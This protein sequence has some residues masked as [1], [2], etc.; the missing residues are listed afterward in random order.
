MEK[1]KI[2]KFA[3]IGASGFVA[4]RHMRAISEN[5]HKL[6][7]ALD[8]HDAVGVLDR[9]FL[10]TDYFR[11]IERF[12]RHLEKLK[13][14]G[15]GVDYLSI[16]SPNYLHDAH[17]RFGLKLG[18]DVICEK[19]LVLNS[20][21]LDGLLEIEKETGQRIYTILQLRLHPEIIK[22]KSKID[23]E[24]NNKFYHIDLDYLTTRGPW[25]NYSWKGDQSKSGGIATNIGIHFFDM[26]IWI[27]GDVI[28]NDMLKLDDNFAEGKLE[29]KNASINWKLS[30]DYNEL[31]KKIKDRGLRMYRSLKID[32]ESF[33]FSGGF[34]D[35]HT[36]S[37]QH[38][39]NEG[40]FGLEETRK[41][42]VLVEKIRNKK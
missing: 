31:P 7:A 20:W 5:G 40:G 22:L 12:D 30:T 9:Y 37:Y 8:P 18:T 32:N 27:F 34:D 16:C 13:R 39:I 28:S 42:I 26:L 35:L 21:N 23:S 19:P 11:E 3:L 1:N 36:K 38:I 29:L 33:E 24:P 41:A 10:E 2:L 6:V 25:Y 17:I 4:P 14:N 15:E